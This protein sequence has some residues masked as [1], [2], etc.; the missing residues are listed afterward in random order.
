M[1]SDLNPKINPMKNLTAA[2]LEIRKATLQSQIGEFKTQIAEL[3]SEISRYKKLSAA[4]GLTDLDASQSS[5]NPWAKKTL[6]FTEQARVTKRNPLLAQELKALA[7][8]AA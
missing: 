5:S 2:A 1:P 7:K 8:K 6:N 3:K 4:R